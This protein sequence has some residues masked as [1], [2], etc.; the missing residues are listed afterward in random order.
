MGGNHPPFGVQL[1]TGPAWF[2]GLEPQ[3]KNGSAMSYFLFVD[4]RDGSLRSLDVSQLSPTIRGLLDIQHIAPSLV[5]ANNGL[6]GSEPMPLI[7]DD[8]RCFFSV[9][10]MG[11]NR[12]LR[13]LDFRGVGVFTCSGDKVSDQIFDT[14]EQVNQAI[15][16]ADAVKIPQ[17]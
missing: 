11:P 3:G 4:A 9:S 14:T 17:P 5:S 1:T 8:G 10:L 6:S 7:M 13:N 16:H 12:E 15:A 2:L